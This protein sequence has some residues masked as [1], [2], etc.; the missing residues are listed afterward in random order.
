V[1]V[2]IRTETK[3]RQSAVIFRPERSSILDTL[4]RRELN[5]FDEAV[6]EFT[7]CEIRGDQVL[8]GLRD[9]WSIVLPRS[10]S[11]ALRRLRVGER[12]GIIRT[13]DDGNPIRVRP[14]PRG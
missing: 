12:V 2:L 1:R 7:G 13:N 10:A 8:V 4:P 3:R 9:S 11:K 6:G 5:D 14:V